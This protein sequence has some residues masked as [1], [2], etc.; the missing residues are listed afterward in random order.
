[1]CHSQLQ[2]NGTSDLDTYDEIDGPSIPLP[3]EESSPQTEES[4]YIEGN[5]T[6]L[7]SVTE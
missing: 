2:D 4:T 6:D 7:N 1:M 5:A 3:V